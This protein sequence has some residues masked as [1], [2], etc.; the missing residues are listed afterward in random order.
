MF[1]RMILEF[2]AFPKSN[3]LVYRVYILVYRQGW[4]SIVD[5]TPPL[6][7]L[8]SAA[9]GVPSGSAHHSG[10]GQGFTQQPNHHGEAQ[11]SYGVVC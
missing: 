10:S 7:S 2:A 8:C 5:G 4:C 11:L 9:G 3:I 6:H 1:F